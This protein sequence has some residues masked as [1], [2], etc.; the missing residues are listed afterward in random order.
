MGRLD[1]PVVRAEN[2]KVWTALGRVEVGAYAPL[3]LQKLLLPFDLRPAVQRRRAWLF[4]T[5]FFGTETSAWH[6]SQRLAR[7]HQLG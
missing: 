7:N 6:Y 2:L 1:R 3:S 5:A 4:G